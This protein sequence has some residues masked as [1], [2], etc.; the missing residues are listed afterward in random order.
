MRAVL[1]EIADPLWNPSAQS[2]IAIRERAKA[3]LENTGGDNEE[4]ADD[5]AAAPVDPELWADLKK[6]KDMPI[7]GNKD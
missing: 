5:A 7:P 3:A 2:A 4:A 6:F 1:A